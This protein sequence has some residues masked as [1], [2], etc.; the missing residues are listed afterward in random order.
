MLWCNLQIHNVSPRIDYDMAALDIA[1]RLPLLVLQTHEPIRVTT[2]AQVHNLSL[3][4]TWQWIQQAIKGPETEHDCSSNF[5]LHKDIQYIAI[6]LLHE[7]DTLI[8]SERGI[9]FLT[10]YMR[11]SDKF[12]NATL[13]VCTRRIQCHCDVTL[14]TTWTNCVISPQNSHFVLC[15]SLDW[16]WPFLALQ[17]TSSNTR[18]IDNSYCCAIHCP[19]LYSG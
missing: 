14:H 17:E 6:P 3:R 8:T 10:Y 12:L 5:S 18:N 4:I 1:C 9:A 11:I 15:T 7:A 19:P 2:T 16:N 13:G